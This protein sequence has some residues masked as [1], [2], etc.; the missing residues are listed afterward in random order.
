MLGPSPVD[1]VEE[2]SRPPGDHCGRMRRSVRRFSPRPAAFESDAMGSYCAC[3]T[4]SSF[5]GSTPFPW[6]CRTTIAARAPASS[7]LVGYLSASSRPTGTSSV[8]PI[9]SIPVALRSHGGE[10]VRHLVERRASLRMQLDGTGAVEQI[11]G[12][13]HPDA[14]L[15]LLD[16]DLLGAN[17]RSQGTLQTLLLQHLVV[18]RLRHA[19]AE[20]GCCKEHESRQCHGGPAV[21]HRSPPFWTGFSIHVRNPLRSLEARAERHATAVRPGTGRRGAPRSTC[22]TLP[23]RGRR[24]SSAGC[25]PR[26][27]RCTRPVPCRP[28]MAPARQAG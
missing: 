7:Q 16:L 1:T 2:P 26:R 11:V 8:F 14:V 23:G 18:L 10:L 25:S 24:T 12:H 13:P 27:R 22:P 4:A 3:D 5:V 9:T 19:A 21:S 6:R 15:E 20:M 28:P 17:L